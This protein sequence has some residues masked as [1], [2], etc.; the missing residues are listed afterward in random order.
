[1]KDRGEV[2]FSFTVGEKE[3][4][5]NSFLIRNPI[6]RRVCSFCV[7]KSLFECLLAVLEQLLVRVHFQGV[8]FSGHD[9]ATKIA[10]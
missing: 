10:N 6:I 4:L 2:P 7:F 9:V 1:M 3:A 8:R 5:S